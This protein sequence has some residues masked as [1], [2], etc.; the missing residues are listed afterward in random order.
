LA[1]YT[2]GYNATLDTIVYAIQT[3]AFTRHVGLIATEAYAL[4]YTSLI[5][6]SALALTT[7]ILDRYGM[8]STVALSA[9][10][11]AMADSTIRAS[12][13]ELFNSA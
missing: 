12:V 5:K 11:D 8:A 4:T 3:L 2:T 6:E 9:G 1:K 7:G 10:I 13:A